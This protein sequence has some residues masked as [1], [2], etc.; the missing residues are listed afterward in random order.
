MLC[1]PKAALMSGERWMRRAAPLSPGQEPL[2][3]MLFY[4]NPRQALLLE[5]GE[6]FCASFGHLHFAHVFKKQSILP[7][8]ACRQPPS[9]VSA[10]HQDAN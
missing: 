4:T 2:P 8:S 3:H 9:P 7:A 6:L 5:Y 1:M 10:G